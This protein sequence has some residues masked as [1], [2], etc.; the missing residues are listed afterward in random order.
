MLNDFVEL[1]FSS[2]T[3]VY[4]IHI[5]NLYIPYLSFIDSIDK[6]DWEVMK[7]E[8]VEVIKIDE[9]VTGLFTDMFCSMKGRQDKA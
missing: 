1:L 8:N 7:Q 4:S 3:W 6:F 9:L 2:L 5:V